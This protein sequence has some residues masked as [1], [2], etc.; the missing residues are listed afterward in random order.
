MDI[1]QV[2]RKPSNKR[3]VSISI[4]ITKHLGAWL[5]ENNVSPTAIF[6]EAVKEIGYDPSATWDKKSKKE[7]KI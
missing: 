1:K 2:T 3:E 5:K 7:K 6:Y 4:K